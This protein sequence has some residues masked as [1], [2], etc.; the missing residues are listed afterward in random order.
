MDNKTIER[1]YNFIIELCIV[2]TAVSLITL[3]CTTSNAYEQIIKRIDK[4]EASK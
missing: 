4:I 1:V 2:I 3:A